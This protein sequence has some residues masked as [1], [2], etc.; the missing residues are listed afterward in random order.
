[1]NNI[2]TLKLDK[3]L[4][5]KTFFVRDILFGNMKS[6]GDFKKGFHFIKTYTCAKCNFDYGVW[7]YADMSNHNQILFPGWKVIY[8]IGLDK[9]NYCA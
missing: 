8:Y 4:I 5:K 1:M 2:P 9:Q 7:K 6:S 3:A